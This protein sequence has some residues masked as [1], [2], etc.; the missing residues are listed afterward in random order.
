MVSVAVVGAVKVLTIVAKTKISIKKK[1]KK[2]KQ[3][4]YHWPWCCRHC[5]HCRFNV[6]SKPKINISVINKQ[7]KHIPTTRLEPLLAVTSAIAASRANS[8][9][10]SGPVRFLA[11]QGLRPRPRPVHIFQKRKKTDQ[12]CKRLKTAVFCG[13]KT[14]LFL[15]KYFESVDILPY[16]VTLI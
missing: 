3:E 12:D 11:L 6:L 14:G 5:C 1:K 15:F 16:F 9:L 2:K 8:V 10:K 4:A 7:K 13:F